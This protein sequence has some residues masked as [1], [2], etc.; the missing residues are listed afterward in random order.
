MMLNKID[1]SFLSCRRSVR[2]VS[3]CA[4]ALTAF[5]AYIPGVSAA[6]LFLPVNRSSL[7]EMPSPVKEIVIANPDIA[8]VH[9]NNSKALTFI[10][11]TAGATNVRIFDETGKLA[12]TLEVT[13]GY[14]LPAIR[15]A[16]KK[17]IP[18]ETINVE[19]VNTSVALTGQVRNNASIDRALKIAQEYIGNS[20][21]DK[22]ATATPAT[23]EGNPYPKI[24]NMM[25]VISGQQ[26]MLRVRVS[27]VNRDALKRLGVDPSL[28]LS[29][30][31]FSMA[32]ALGEGISGL[33]AGATSAY[34]LA[35]ADAFRGTQG[36]FWQ[37]NPSHRAGAVI[38]ALERDGLIKTLAEPNLVA[39]S[40]E[41]AEFLAGGEIP[42]V[43]PSSSSTGAPTVTTEYK[44]FGVSVKFTPDVLS[45]NRIRM[46]VQPE[47][48]E[49]SS[50]N[51]IVLSGFTIPSI[52]TRRA[53]TTIEL[54]PGESFMIAGLIKDNTKAS[55]DQIPGVKELPVLGALFRSTEFQRNETELVISVTPYLVDPLKSSD[56]K[57][58]TD[59]FR[60]ASQVEMFFYGALGAI[61]TGENSVKIPQVEIEGPTGFMMD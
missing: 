11:K 47:V 55:I 35:D 7:V 17:F 4:C 50:A 56:V 22:V 10:G 61:M 16:I 5:V 58:P 29:G 59:D 14:D 46:V 57:L 32:G 21:G 25:K 37:S 48:S 52:T 49:I 15:R 3:L 41:Q 39:I 60:P 18:D 42:V 45:Q 40:G 12:Q 30:R 19:M 31:N 1:M 34:T 24:L 36:F 2:Y 43:T 33:A 13:V 8:D 28:V 53:K 26:V 51:S 20:A 38:S 27:E 54:A 23:T 6:G 44:P 9:V